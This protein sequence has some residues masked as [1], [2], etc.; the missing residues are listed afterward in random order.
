MNIFFASA[1]SRGN[2]FLPQSLQ[3]HHANRLKYNPVLNIQGAFGPMVLRHRGVPNESCTMSMPSVGKD[4]PP[5]KEV[6]VKDNY[7]FS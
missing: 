6:T 1:S 2:G 4:L 7:L 3:N 5:Q